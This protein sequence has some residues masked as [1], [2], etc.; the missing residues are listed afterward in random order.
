MDFK[1]SFC[2]GFNL[3]NDDII[4]V[5]CCCVFRPPP[6]LKT[7]VENDIFGLKQGQDLENWAAHPHQEFA[8]VPH[9]T[10]HLNSN[11]NDFGPTY[12]GKVRVK[13]IKPYCLKKQRVELQLEIAY[14]K[15]KKA[16]TMHHLQSRT[17]SETG[18]S[19]R[20]VGLSCFAKLIRII[21]QGRR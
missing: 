7:D 19:T 18:V 10:G 21:S 13:I 2:C 14:R 5:L 6:G 3:S 8:G 11:I 9:S 20:L 16:L 17:C 4:S 15:K 12:I 1:N